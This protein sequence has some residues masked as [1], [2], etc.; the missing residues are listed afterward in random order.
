MDDSL[1]VNKSKG[2]A[3]THNN[4][5]NKKSPLENE[6]DEMQE[7]YDEDND[8]FDMFSCVQANKKRKVEKVHITD[9]YTTGNNANLSDNW[10]DSEGYYKVNKIYMYFINVFKNIS[11][12]NNMLM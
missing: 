1:Y 4:L 7:E 6:E 9:Y 11:I 3:D 10:N 12:Y 8:D 5:T 2:N